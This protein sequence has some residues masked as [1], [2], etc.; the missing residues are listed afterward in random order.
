[1]EDLI[2]SQRGVYNN[3]SPEFVVL[4]EEYGA[5]LDTHTLCKFLSNGP[6]ASWLMEKV[7]WKGNELVLKACFSSVLWDRQVERDL[8]NTIC[9]RHTSRANHS[10][11]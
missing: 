10:S 7:Q 6:V 3:A 2:Q 4:M 9:R 5:I 1:M 11:K 8:L